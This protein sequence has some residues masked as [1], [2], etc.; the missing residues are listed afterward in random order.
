MPRRQT[1]IRSMLYFGGTVTFNSLIVYVAYNFDKLLLGRVWGPDA[2]GTYT[3]AYQLV[4]IPTQNLNSAIGGIGFSVLARLQDDPIRL[5]NYFLK[6]YGLITAATLPATIFGALFADDI[7]LV[8]L[9]PKWEEA[10]IIFRLM[11]PTVLVFGIMNPLAW[12][13][14]SMGLQVRSLWIALV[15]APLLIAAYFIGLPYGPRGVALTYSA[16]MI[17]WLVPSVVWCLYG[18]TIRPLDLLLAAGRP[19]LSGIVAAVFAFGVQYYCHRLLNVIPR[20]MVG[21]GTMVCVYSWMLL[22]VMG[23]KAFYLDLFRSLQNRS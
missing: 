9:G 15:M 21:G 5:K 16:T 3:R 14:Q 7:V 22:F 19:L 20:L 10:A 12:L 4:N 11:T 13:L 23:Q 18:T 8:V 2:L 1:E 17:L 6:G